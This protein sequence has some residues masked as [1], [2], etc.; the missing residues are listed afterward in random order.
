MPRLD[1]DEIWKGIRFVTGLPRF[2]HGRLSTFTAERTLHRRFEARES[3]FLNLAK[4]TIYK[5]P[6]SPYGPLLRSAG[7]EYGDLEH[8]VIGH[9]LEGALRI[10]LRNGVYLTLD[11]FKGRR[12]VVRGTTVVEAGPA[13]L[14]NP[15]SR[16]AWSAQSSGT[17]G[18]AAAVNFDLDFV[19]DRA[20]NL[21]LFLE[22]RGGIGWRHAIWGVPGSTDLIMLLELA[23]VGLR[24]LRW[25]S[26]VRTG[27]SGLHPRY[28]WSA[29]I[30]RWSSRLAARPLPPPIDAPLDDPM[31][32]VRWVRR[33]LDDGHTPHVTTFVTPA[34]RMCQAAQAW[35]VDITG[36][37]LTLG[38]EPLT[39]AR[40][41]MLRR[42][43]ASAVP[44]FLAIESGYIGYGC[45]RPASPD[46]NH[47][48]DDFNA[49]ITAGP[50]G[51][52]AG[53]P[54]RAILITSLRST[55]PVILFNVSLGD[56][57]EL[58][59]HSCDCPVGRL[60]YATH[61]S[62]IRSFER[63]KS[64]GMTFLDKDIVPILEQVLPG[65]F[66][67]TVLDY[68]LSE[69]ER[70][71]GTPEMVIIISPSVGAL[72]ERAVVEVFL[73]AIGRGSGAERVMG[74]QWRSGNYLR[75]ERRVPERTA[76][77]KI[78]HLLKSRP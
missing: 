48:I 23:G 30:V 15:L 34:I 13:A 16:P 2:L 25:F 73:E 39:Q 27:A 70:E 6:R 66:G 20:V 22:S 74:L 44:R 77:G 26:Q 51:E 8:L 5:N 24:S 3:D 12:P 29:R 4:R 54:P 52:A 10:L 62:H 37:Q 58:D 75:V 61:I 43:G 57:A 35:G 7:C 56:E 47:L 46:D 21:R 55:V 67:G 72:D 63:L 14:G 40:L 28:V 11:E 9:G 38:G 42:A 64:G 76:T 60:G 19:R 33:V 31:P 45:L 69:R 18:R 49:V 17:S 65:R 71:D 78:K 32:L 68:Q 36:T 59:R 1:L 41:E 53:L 50:E